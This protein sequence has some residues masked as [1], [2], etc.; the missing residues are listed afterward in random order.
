MSRPGNPDRINVHLAL[1]LRRAG[2]SWVRIGAE[3]A[4]QEHRPICYQ[5]ASVRVAV[6][7]YLRDGR[8]RALK[9]ELQR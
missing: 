3:L 6:D 1:E 5:G 7:R 2:C 8:F 4:R 9:S